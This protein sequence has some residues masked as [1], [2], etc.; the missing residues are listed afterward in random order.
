MTLKTS[1]WALQEP[2]AIFLAIIIRTMMKLHAFS[3]ALFR[4]VH[5]TVASSEFEETIGSNCLDD[6]FK[7]ISFPD[8]RDLLA[9]E[10]VFKDKQ[11]KQKDNFDFKN[12]H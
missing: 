10:Q 2:L 6:L 12:R 11:K 3:E 8:Q 4:S 5:A 7:G 1:R 9:L